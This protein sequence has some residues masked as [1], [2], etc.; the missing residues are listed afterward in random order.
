VDPG[1]EMLMNG[2]KRLDELVQFHLVKE[3]MLQKQPPGL[4]ESVEQLQERQVKLQ[5]NV[6]SNIFNKDAKAFEKRIHGY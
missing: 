6:F 4:Q 3:E 5:W 2:A 1:L